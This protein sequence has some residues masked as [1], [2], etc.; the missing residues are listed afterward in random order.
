MK[1]WGG[2]FSKPASKI[3]EEF[4]SSLSFD[5]RLY[6]EDIAGSIAH[7]RMLAKTGII[8]EEDA[9]LIENG[10][11]EIKQEIESDTF[12]WRIEFEDLHLNIEKRLH[13]IVGPVAGKLHTA[14][15][16]NDQIALDEHMFVLA[17]CDHLKQAVTALQRSIVEVSDRHRDAI[18][19]GYTHMQRA[20]PTLFAHHMLAY[21]F[22]LERDYGRFCDCS[23]RA[24]AMPLGAGALA[25]TTFPID[26]RVVADE[27]GFDELY[28]NSMDAVSDRDHLIETVFCCAVTSMHLSR[29]AEELILWSTTE[30]G[31]VEMDD[32]YS[33]GSSIM[34]Q[35]KNPDVLELIRG[36][37]GRVYGSLMSLLTLMKG[38]P[39]AYNSDMQEDK[40][41]LFDAVD[42]VGACL[43]LMA[44][45]VSTMKV[46][47][48]KML[49]AAKNDFSCAT[50]VADYLAAR[51][52]PFRKAHEITGRL[53]AKCIE[54]AK[55][56]HE[57]SIEDYKQASELFESDVFDLIKV[58]T[59]VARRNSHGGTGPL[60]TAEQLQVAAEIV[61]GRKH[62]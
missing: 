41:R 11:V 34:P 13:E 24:D 61:R 7:V 48:H 44:A 4:T 53:V 51:G 20:Q 5:R 32:A 59:S 2:R 60:R 36:K 3:A 58:E 26:P 23:K 38:T 27:L 54:E 22:M 35:K 43:A 16:R 19:P 28:S 15:S 56:L 21:F 62:D 29:L 49:L 18:M 45:V 57:L 52:M 10:L 12:P 8:P 50:D 33:T 40:E 1:L 14:R 37:T 17:A 30:F 39:L 55:Y 25:G 42:T 6:R 9:Q 47:T 31:F 46:N